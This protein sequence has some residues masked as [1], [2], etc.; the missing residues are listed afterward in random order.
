MEVM[1]DLLFHCLFATSSTVYL[2]CV[3]FNLSVLIILRE[4]FF[5]FLVLDLFHKVLPLY[6]FWM[7]QWGVNICIEVGIPMTLHVLFILSA[8]FGWNLLYFDWY[9]VFF[10]LS[11]IMDLVVAFLYQPFHFLVT[12]SEQLSLKQLIL[13]TD[14]PG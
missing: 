2:F 8:L 7:A 11:F 10:L 5:I 9:A 14:I 12:Y 13:W 1:A 6:S 4:L 3:Y